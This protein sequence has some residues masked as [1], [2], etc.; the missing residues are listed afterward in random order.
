MAPD[1]G[2]QP[3][4]CKSSGGRKDERRLLVAARAAAEE[5]EGDDREGDGEEPGGFLLAAEATAAG[6]AGSGWDTGLLPS[7]LSTLALLASGL[8]PPSLPA[9]VLVPW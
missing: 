6:D 1:P 5:E 4:G 2:G 3:I 8:S 9:V 7:P